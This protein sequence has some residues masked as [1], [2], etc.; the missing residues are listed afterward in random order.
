MVLQG[1]MQIVADLNRKVDA[2]A[3]RSPQEVAIPARPKAG[4]PIEAKTPEDTTALAETPKPKLRI[5]RS[6]LLNLFD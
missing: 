2:L 1:L 4:V 3:I 5:N 6:R